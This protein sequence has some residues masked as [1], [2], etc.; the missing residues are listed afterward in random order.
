MGGCFGTG[1]FK[2]GQDAQVWEDSEPRSCPAGGTSQPGCRD[3]LIRPLGKQLMTISDVTGS[4]RSKE[5]CM[6]PNF[7]A[8]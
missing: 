5:E 6:L 3:A 4:E 1:T 8:W 7:L 2:F